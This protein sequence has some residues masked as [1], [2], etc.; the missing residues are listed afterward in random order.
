MTDTEEPL[1]KLR[2]VEME[3]EKDGQQLKQASDTAAL[4]QDELIEAADR[5][6]QL[7][8]QLDKMKDDVCQLQTRLEQ[9]S[10]EFDDFKQ[11][12]TPLWEEEMKQRDSR[13]IEFELHKSDCSYK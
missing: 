13:F 3:Q 10:M 11:R 12:S 5:E 8:M 9:R 6:R 1:R 4:L 2:R 7:Q